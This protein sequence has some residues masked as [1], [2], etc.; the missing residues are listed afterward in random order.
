M[1]LLVAEAVQGSHI[2]S[3]VI[4]SRE[5]ILRSRFCIRTVQTEVRQDVGT[6]DMSMNTENSSDCVDVRDKGLTI[7][8][9]LNT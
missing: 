3:C 2:C 4:A 7:I 9:V 1:I 6:S 8:F 5:D